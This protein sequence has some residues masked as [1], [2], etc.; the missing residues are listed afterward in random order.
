MNEYDQKTALVTG[1]NSG[2]GRAFVE[3]LLNSGVEKFYAT[4][5]NVE[6]L[7]DLVAQGE[8]RVIPV[9]IDITRPEM[10]E[11]AVAGI[12]N[13]NILINNAGVATFKGLL[14]AD[15]TDYARAE[16]EVNY[17]GTP[18]MVRAFAPVLAA[19]GGG[20][21]VNMSSIIGRVNF[22]ILGSLNWTGVG[23]V[24]NSF[25]HCR[26]VKFLKSGIAKDLML[27]VGQR[28]LLPFRFQFVPF[29][30]PWYDAQRRSG[31]LK[32]F[33]CGPWR[34]DASIEIGRATTHCH[35]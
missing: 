13:L 15:S 1:A 29:S 10:I 27:L 30:S 34:Y 23:E 9:E 33:R 22:P 14:A 7:G 16:M 31:S 8:G 6:T 4:A 21:I 19:S 26:V 20:T 2:I 11:Q 18:N 32:V 24:H 3:A 35:V 25:L 17:Y 28:T 12:S 5:R